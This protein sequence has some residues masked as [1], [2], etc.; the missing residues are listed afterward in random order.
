MVDSW[1]GNTRAQNSNSF[2]IWLSS[3]S[4]HDME[5]GKQSKMRRPPERGPEEL[6][7]RNTDH[8]AFPESHASRISKHNNS[9]LGGRRQV[10]T[11]M[12]LIG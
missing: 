4:N 11:I 10:K 8:L 12:A 3:D 7:G 2:G 6:Q 5:G 9:L 1:E